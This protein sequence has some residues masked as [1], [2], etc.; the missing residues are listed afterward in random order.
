MAKDTVP[1][2]FLSMDRGAAADS[3]Q[4]TELLPGSH[5]KQEKF[6]M[7][8]ILAVPTCDQLE[9]LHSEG[10]LSRMEF[11]E[12]QVEHGELCYLNHDVSAQVRFSKI[13]IIII[14]FHLTTTLNQLTSTLNYK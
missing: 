12:K 10:Q 7:S 9:K 13:I 4:E 14:L 1:Q 6:W 11:L 5:S 3:L 2:L 8:F